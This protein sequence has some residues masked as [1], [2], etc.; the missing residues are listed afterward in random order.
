VLRPLNHLVLNLHEV[1]LLKGL[2]PKVVV[3]VIAVI[4]DGRVQAILMLLDDVEGLLGD[5]GSMLLGVGVDVIVEVLHNGRELLLGLLVEVGDGNAGSQESIIWMLGGQVGSSLS[6]ESVK[7]AGPHSLVDAN[8]N[9]T[10]K[11]REK[12]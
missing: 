8:Y 9:L 6:G 10:E 12:A 5:Q 4:D 11:E 1:G 7:V 3:A 2:E